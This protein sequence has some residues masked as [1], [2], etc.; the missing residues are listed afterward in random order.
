M[1]GDQT[2]VK[3]GAEVKEIWRK[4]AI[5][6]ATILLLDWIGQGQD[7]PLLSA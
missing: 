1:D 5:N 4:E 3:T 6:Q 7:L 2:Q